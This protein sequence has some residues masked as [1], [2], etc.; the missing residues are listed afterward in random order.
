MV[1]LMQEPLPGVSVRE[2]ETAAVA[3][4]AVDEF[5]MHHV[6]ASE[7]SFKTARDTHCMLH[8][9]KQ[10]RTPLPQTDRESVATA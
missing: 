3:P 5:S 2:T 8:G 6:E 7:G 10:L 4:S 9:R 1:T